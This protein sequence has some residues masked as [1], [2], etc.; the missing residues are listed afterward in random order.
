MGDVS[1]TT[2]VWAV[3]AG[4]VV[5]GSV[6]ALCCASLKRCRRA[7][8]SLWDDIYFRLRNRCELVAA[9]SAELRKL[10]PMDPKVTKDIDYLLRRM[11]ETND[12]F[13][14]AGVQNGIVLT[15]QTAVE[16]FHRDERFRNSTKI[17]KTMEDIGKLDSNLAHLRDR[18]N[19]LVQKYNTRLN[20][21]PFYWAGRLI[22]AE[23]KPLFP[24]LIPW[25]STDP[26]AYGA[27]TADDIRTQLQK[28]KAPLVLAPSQR[29][30]WPRLRPVIQVS[31]KLRGHGPGAPGGGGRGTA[32]SQGGPPSGVAVL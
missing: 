13:T 25:W 7:V 5:T 6:L 9:L 8:N 22:G 4:A 19:A 32:A 29:E 18:F 28:S 26:A 3:A 16:Q 17:A 24:M 12:A 2:V 21:F 1:A 23:E 20:A 27:V 11:E 10:L 31:D 30:E 14:H 15:V